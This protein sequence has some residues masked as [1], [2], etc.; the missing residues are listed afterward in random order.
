MISAREK[1]F[2]MVNQFLADRIRNCED[3]LE[4][5][6]SV[7]AEQAPTP[8]EAQAP[9]GQVLPDVESYEEL[10]ALA[11]E[12]GYTTSYR[13]DDLLTEE[14]LTRLD[15]EYAQIEADFAEATKLNKTDAGFIVIAAALQLI[16][17]VLQPKL[18]VTVTP[19]AA[20]EGSLKLQS[21]SFGHASHSGT[22]T[23]FLKD[24]R[25]GKDEEVRE[26]YASLEDISNITGYAPYDVTKGADEHGAHLNILNHKYKTLG[27]D[28]YFGYFFGTCNILTNAMSVAGRDAFK[29]VHVH[30]NCVGEDADFEQ[31]LLHCVERFKESPKTVALALLKQAYHVASGQKKNSKGGVSQTLLKLLANT[32]IVDS[33]CDVD[34][35]IEHADVYLKA[36]VKQGTIAELVNFLIAVAHRMTMAAEEYQAAGGEGITLD[37]V[38]QFNVFNKSERLSEVRTRKILIISNAIASGI[39][40]A[41]IGSTAA[42]MGAPEN[43]QVMKEVL[44][45]LDVGGLVVTCLHLFSDTRFITKIKK[46]YLAGVI[47]GS[48]ESIVTIV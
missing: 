18:K 27:H 8:D 7:G 48:A 17:Q 26:Y 2:M 25:S 31:V 44:Q 20:K 42:V 33:L 29:T 4:R 41:A 23:E 47:Q 9:D 38:R 12:A 37:V 19:A 34:L 32:E 30:N 21:A 6:S 46:D 43:P 14:E 40:L 5:I 35:D 1:E 45:N 3:R 10:A 13:A 39:N 36:A 16:R 11:R 28:Q 15:A 24:N 22:I